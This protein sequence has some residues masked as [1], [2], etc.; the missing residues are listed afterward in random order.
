[1]ARYLVDTSALVRL[2]RHEEAR[3]GWE[4]HIAAGVI[5]CC[6]I[7]ELELMYAARSKAD[8][9]EM[10][11]VLRAAFSWVTMPD[12][13]FERAAEVQAALT[14]AGA[15]RSAGAVDLL[16]AAAAECHGLTL[17]HHDRDFEQV[18]RVTG[19]PAQWLFRP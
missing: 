8:R 4:Q 2:I 10:A 14:A 7:V 19:Q 3:A 17:L 9:E 5:A 12:R 11:E 6:P 13:V 15:H 1:M 16:V 18:A